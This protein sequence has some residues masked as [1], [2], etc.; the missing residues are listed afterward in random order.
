MERPIQYILHPTYCDKCGCEIKD[1]STCYDYQDST[2]CP[3]CFEEVLEDLKSECEREA[4][5]AEEMI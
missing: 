5:S 4:E 3:S 2:Y 1:G